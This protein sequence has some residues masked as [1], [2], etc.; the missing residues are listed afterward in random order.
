[1]GALRAVT[2]QLG[3]QIAVHSERGAGTR[4]AITFS[5]DRCFDA[6]PQMVA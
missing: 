5:C 3:G 1:M 2:L 4:L 6:R